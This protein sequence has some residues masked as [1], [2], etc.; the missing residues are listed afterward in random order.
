[1]DQMPVEVTPV[2]VAELPVDFV[3]Y[4]DMFLQDESLPEVI[5][6]SISEEFNRNLET[7]DVECVMNF[8]ESLVNSYGA[9]RYD[10]VTA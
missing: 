5:R 7:G 1:M 10:E 9:N 2:E 8:L 4:I 6:S 3:S